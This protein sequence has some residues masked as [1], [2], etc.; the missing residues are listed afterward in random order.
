ME[1]SRFQKELADSEIKRY[2]L[3]LKATEMERQLGLSID[4]IKQIRAKVIAQAPITEFPIIMSPSQSAANA[5][6]F[7]FAELESDE[8]K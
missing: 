1:K 7:G 5:T 6:T 4:I 3:Y 2:L 8:E